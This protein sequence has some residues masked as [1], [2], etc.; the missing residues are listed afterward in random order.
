[1]PSSA[2]YTSSNH[3]TETALSIIEYLSAGREP[4]RLRDISEALAINASTA[5]RFL[6]TLIQCGYVEQDADSQRYHMTYK[7]CR[8]ACQIQDNTELQSLTHPYLV[9]LSAKFGEACCVSVE[10][11]GVM[12]YVDTCSPLGQSLMSRQQIGGSAPMHCTGNGKLALLNYSERQL[13]AWIAERGL[14]GYTEHTIT[15]RNKLLYELSRIRALG[16]AEDREECELGVRCLAFPIRDYSGKIVAG[17]SITGPTSR[18][19]DGVVESMK[20]SL[21]KAAESISRS[22]GTA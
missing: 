12:I 7:L 5:S 8:L 6:N 11:G 1:M 14:A 13:D 15:E 19:N 4:K 17:I 21:A 9:A 22:L 10:R 20:P 2:P 3:S 18:M 16:F